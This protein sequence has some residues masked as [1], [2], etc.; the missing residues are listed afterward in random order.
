MDTREH[1]RSCQTEGQRLNLV[2]LS[3]RHALQSNLGGTSGWRRDF[4]FL[5]EMFRRHAESVLN[6]G[7][8]G[9]C[10]E[11]AVEWQ[12]PSSIQGRPDRRCELREEL[13]KLLADA[14]GVANHHASSLTPILER[15]LEFLRQ[16]EVTVLG[17]SETGGG[18]AASLATGFALL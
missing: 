5:T 9:A 7:Q 16:L 13:S 18:G 17:K 4:Q 10:M 1:L 6:L 11:F 12:D 3:L 2:I 8:H 14:A 15:M